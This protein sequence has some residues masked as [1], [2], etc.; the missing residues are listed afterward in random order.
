MLSEE[1]SLSMADVI[2]EE[3]N[4]SCLNFSMLS[5]LQSVLKDGNDFCN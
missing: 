4:K 1:F 2:A 5:P 3:K